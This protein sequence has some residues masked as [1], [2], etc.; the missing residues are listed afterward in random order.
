MNKSK[1]LTFPFPDRKFIRT[2]KMLELGFSYY[3]I[4]RFIKDGI[5]ERINGNTFE[6][7]QYT[8]EENE[9]LY[10]DGYIEQGVVCLMSAAVYHGISTV[11]PYQIDVAIPIKSKVSILP[12]WPSIGIFYFSDTRYQLG[13]ERISFDGGSC[14]IYDK[15]KTVCDLLAYRNKYG[16][17]DC[18]D[19]L[20]NYLREEDRDINKLIR[21]AQQLRSYT[22]LSKYLEVLL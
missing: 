15:E 13:I 6:N 12:D 7:L 5:I 8:M 9:F 3:M 17:E 11:R 14:A 2:S 18:L 20:K 16:Q 4:H 22:I 21:Y 10:V 1:P 19:V